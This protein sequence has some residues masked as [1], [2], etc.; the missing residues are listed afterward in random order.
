MFTLGI[1]SR[2]FLGLDWRP[3][4]AWSGWAR[5]LIQNT[6]LHLHFTETSTLYAQNTKQS[7]TVLEQGNRKKTAYPRGFMENSLSDIGY[8]F[9]SRFYH[10]I[11]LFLSSLSSSTFIYFSFSFLRLAFFFSVPLL[12]YVMPPFFLSSYLSSNLLSLFTSFHSTYS[13]FSFTSSVY[14]LIYGYV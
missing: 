6:P 11:S 5:H 7:F 14:L 3:W 10:C 13:F 9:L 4:E 2:C 1:K 12:S 8:A